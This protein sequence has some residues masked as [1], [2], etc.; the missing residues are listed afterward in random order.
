[1]VKVKFL[2]PMGIHQPAEDENGIWN[3]EAAGMKVSDLLE[4]TP[5][6]DVKMGYAI[7][8]NQAKQELDYILQDED[9][10][11]VLPLFYAG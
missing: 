6:K 5:L 11:S 10:L 7:R 4:T 8:V 1:M 9:N 2:G 3:V